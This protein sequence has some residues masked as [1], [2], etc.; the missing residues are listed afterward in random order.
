MP[1][2]AISVF[3]IFKIGV[4]PSSSHTLGPWRA[5]RRFVERLREAGELA[6]VRRLRVELYG[7][8]AKTGRGHGTDVAVVLGL[9]GEEPE[10]C[11][12]T[13]LFPTIERVRC[14]GRLELAGGSAVTFQP[15]E[16]IFFR[17]D[18]TLPQH[19]NAL[20]FAAELDGGV[21]EALF[22]SIGG[23]FVVCEGEAPA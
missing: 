20:R 23:G 5:A 3:D 1:H 16:D 11:D 13:A 7:S 2:E 18:V 19:P 9:L 15:A 21:R 14:S 10:T 6:D 17:G 8:L 22:F 12:T 4:G